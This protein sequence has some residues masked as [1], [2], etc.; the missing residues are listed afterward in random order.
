MGHLEKSFR[1]TVGPLADI[2]PD[3]VPV[4]NKVAYWMWMVGTAARVQVDSKAEAWKMS[5]W[6]MVVVFIVSLIV[7]IAVGAFIAEGMGDE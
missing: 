4:D 6:I 3:E 7:A 5:G 1:D 2:G